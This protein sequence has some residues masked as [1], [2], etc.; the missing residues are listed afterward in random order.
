MLIA[1]AT[2]PLG[3]TLTL[4]FGLT[5]LSNSRILLSEAD[6]SALI[7]GIGEMDLQTSVAPPVGSFAFVVSGQVSNDPSFATAY[8]QPVAIGGVFKIDSANM[9]SGVADENLNGMMAR[10]LALT[11]DIGPIDSFGAI[12]INLNAAFPA[13]SSPPGLVSPPLQL[14]GYVV[15]AQHIMLVGQA[16][17][18]TTLGFT[19]GGSALGQGSSAGTF[20]ANSALSGPFV[21]GI[22]GQSQ[23][24]DDLAMP[25]AL[26]T[27][28]AS[29]VWAGV[30]TS[31]GAGHLTNGSADQE[32]GF[33]VPPVTDTLTGSYAVDPSGIGRATVTTNFAAAGPGPNG[34]RHRS[35]YQ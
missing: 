10:N 23:T 2:T 25:T 3:T 8:P 34:Q 27:V 31:D 17:P 30:F 33:G 21:Y 29:A 4:S 15:D 12:T 35:R 24:I 14:T 32:V 13:P 22:L 5:I 18:T 19:L 28:W 6:S 20:N 11:G 7:S 16:D 9:I 1:N 26:P